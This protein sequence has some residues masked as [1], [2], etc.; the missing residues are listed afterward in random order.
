MAL[1]PHQNLYRS[2]FIAHL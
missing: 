2:S 1:K